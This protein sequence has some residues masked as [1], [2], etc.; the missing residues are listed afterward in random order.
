MDD[1]DNPIGAARLAGLRRALHARPRD[2]EA[3]RRA[4]DAVAASRATWAGV[5]TVL[6]LK[7][8]SAPTDGRL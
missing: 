3:I 2:A 7:L 8:A 4:I 6:L 1:G 5:A